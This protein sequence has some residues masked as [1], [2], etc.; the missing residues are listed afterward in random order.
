MRT[1]SLRRIFL[2][3]GVLLSVCLALAVVCVTLLLWDTTA[4][5][6]SFR[7]GFYASLAATALFAAGAVI[8][9]LYRVVGA[10]LRHD[11]LSLTRMFRDVR[12]GALRENYPLALREFAEALSYLRSSG[13]KLVRE[14]K[15]LQNLGLIDH[16]S[17]LSNRRHFERRLTHLYEAAKSKGTSSVLLIDLDH[18]KAVNDKH[19]HDAGDLLIV[20]FAKALRA[21]V[22]QTD[23]LARLGGDEFCIIYP[24]TRLE[25]ASAYVERLR[26]QLPRELPLLNGAVHALRWTGGVSAITDGDKKFDDVLWRADKALF[27]AKEAGRNNTKVYDPRY[28]LKVVS[29]VSAR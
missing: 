5:A 10:A 20:N 23:F 18:F 26:R 27:H 13:H 28:A 17:Q 15:R 6:V 21:C 7:S 4:P 22:R 25:K 3:A 12:D 2:K 24:Y 11:V 1:V 19:G 8:V 16:L 14:K 29:Q 9:R